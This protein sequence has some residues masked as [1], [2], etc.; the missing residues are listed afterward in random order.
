MKHWRRSVKTPEHVA[1]PILHSH[2]LHQICLGGW[3]GGRVGRNIFHGKDHPYFNVHVQTSR[4]FIEILIASCYIRLKKIYWIKCTS[5]SENRKTNKIICI[6][7]KKC[8][9][10]NEQTALRQERLSHQRRGV[11]NVTSWTA[12]KIVLRWSLY[13]ARICTKSYFET[14]Q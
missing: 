13:T 4:I 6:Y 12:R 5:T 10:Q 1:L 8:F 7:V 11:R 14:L 9:K 2:M 3:G